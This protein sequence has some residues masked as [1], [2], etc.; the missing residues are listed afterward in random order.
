VVVSDDEMRYELWMEA[1]GQP[2]QIH[3]EAT[4]TRRDS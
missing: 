1:V 2:H 4:L 3:L